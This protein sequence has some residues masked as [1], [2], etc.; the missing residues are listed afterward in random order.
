MPAFSYRAL[1]ARGQAVN[2]VLEAVD[3]AAAAAALSGRGLFP[4][5][6]SAGAS[7]A[8][9]GVA[10]APRSRVKAHA[11]TELT[12][13]L[14]G[15]LAAGF[16]LER[17]LAA[18]SAQGD[19]AATNALVAD[20]RRRITE[21]ATFSAALEAYPAL[22]PGLYRA[23]VRAGE[24]GGFLPDALTR[25]TE[26]REREEELAGRVRAALTYPAI[27]AAVM[28][29][30]VGV[31]MTFVIPSIAQMFEGME[32]ALPAPTQALIALSDAVV[33]WWPLLVLAPVAGWYALRRALA[34]PAGR[35]RFDRL[36][37]ALPR[38]GDLAR[39]VAVTRFARTLST[40]LTS[41]VPLLDGLAIAREVADNLV[42]KEAI[43]AAADRVTRGEPLGPPLA[44]SGVF[45]P[46]TV[47]MIVLGEE[48]G[49]LAAMLARVATRYDREVATALDGLVVLIEPVMTV[50]MGTVIGAVVLAMVMPIFELGNTV[51]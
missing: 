37:L 24:A 26:M 18:L 16:P 29:A 5:A 8:P 47:Q 19:G 13:Q 42:L 14:A 22:F 10:P 20:L 4:T 48:S 45:P 44:E 9:A 1:D 7:A 28:V 15:L 30:V 34:T 39:K 25:L 32:H 11:I 12:G 41:G 46:L 6:V 27:M 38:L 51:G 50:V 17:A 35:R 3:A 43:A 31:I 49:T 23:L 36:V 40:L 33:R 21:G 2:G